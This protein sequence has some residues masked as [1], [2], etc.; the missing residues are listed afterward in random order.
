MGKKPS[1]KL[2][3]LLE[4][5]VAA[6]LTAADQKLL[7]AE[8]TDR[9]ERPIEEAEVEEQARKPP[10]KQD[11]PAERLVLLQVKAMYDLQKLRLAMNNRICAFEPV[12]KAGKEKKVIN[13]LD[14]EIYRAH[15]DAKDIAQMQ[16]TH[17]IL[18]ELEKGF[19]SLVLKALRGIGIW[20]HWL[21]GQKGVG[22]RMGGFLVA[23]TDIR[24]CD[25]VSQLWSW[26]G[27][28]LIGDEIQKMKAGEKANYSPERK[29]R[30]LEVLGTSLMRQKSEP[31]YSHYQAY[32]HRKTSQQVPQCMRCGG[33]GKV[34]AKTKEEVT[35]SNCAGTG[36]PVSWGASEYHRHRAALRYMVK[37]FLQEF[38]RQWRMLEGLPVPP[39]YSEVY[40]ADSHPGP[41]KVKLH[42]FSTP[43]GCCPHCQDRIVPEG[44][45]PQEHILIQEQ[46]QLGMCLSPS[47]PKCKIALVEV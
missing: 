46:A 29:S 4:K 41:T 28:G 7:D 27:L 36:G 22:P 33:T 3:A 38:W 9:E 45:L 42:K 17:D 13:S 2:I 20:E 39:P 25:T 8:S 1:S 30:V 14:M 12:T 32:R 31:W 24:L 15:L 23:E 19:A 40:L 37:M 18:F 26:Y 16:N 21:K 11:R 44:I 34:L 5:S 6:E 10:K 43:G 47:C 35:C